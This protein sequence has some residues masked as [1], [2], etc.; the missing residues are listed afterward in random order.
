MTPDPLKGL[1]ADLEEGDRFDF[2]RLS[3]ADVDAR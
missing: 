1:M 3:I 2:S